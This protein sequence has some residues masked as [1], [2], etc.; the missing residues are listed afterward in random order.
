[1]M[2]M[3]DFEVFFLNKIMLLFMANHKD[4]DCVKDTLLWLHLDYPLIASTQTVIIT[5]DIYSLNQD[6]DDEKR[7]KKNQKLTTVGTYR[8]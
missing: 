3:A 7:A 6:D 8:V 1:M 4:D 2:E 5:A